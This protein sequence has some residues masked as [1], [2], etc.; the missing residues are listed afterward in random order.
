MRFSGER[1]LH[2]PL[3]QVWA[4]L[5]DPDVLRTTIPGCVDLVPL[6]S[7]RYAATL[8][9]RVGPLADTYCGAFSIEDLRPGSALRVRVEGRG[10][11]GRLDV[12]LRVRLAEGRTA[13]TTLRYDADASV[14][15]LVAR[16]G[17]AT[18]SVAGGHLTGCYFRD[19]D[20]ALRHH[21][22]MS[23]PATTRTASTRTASTR[24]ASLA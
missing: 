10:R 23:R 9:A 11:C 22:P 24:T 12:D 20:R 17:Q 16:L 21:A 2:T 6:G 3:A 19:L 14:R 4:A 1:A 5:H 8:A 13:P 18:L 15:G 7:G